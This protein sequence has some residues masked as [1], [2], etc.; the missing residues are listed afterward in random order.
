MPHQHSTVPV[1]SYLVAAESLDNATKIAMAG[2][3]NQTIFYK[4]CV[5]GKEVAR[6]FAPPTVPPLPP[7]QPVTCQL[8]H[9][10]PLDSLPAMARYL[11]ANGYTVTKKKI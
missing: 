4:G 7:P 1:T 10:P 11:R 3:Q 8:Q 9:T 2:L 5:D 6:E